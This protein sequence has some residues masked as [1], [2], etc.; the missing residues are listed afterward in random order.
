MT[1]LESTK[2]AP[3]LVWSPSLEPI[4]R[5][6]KKQRLVLEPEGPQEIDPGTLTGGVFGGFGVKHERTTDLSRWAAAAY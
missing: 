3:S 1:G 4:G 2:N 5:K 6:R